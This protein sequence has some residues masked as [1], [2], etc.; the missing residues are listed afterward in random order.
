MRK[1]TMRRSVLA[2]LAL[3][4]SADVLS[5]Q[6][7]RPTSP[8]TRRDDAREVLHGVELVDPYRWLEDDRSPETR[9]WIEAGRS[10]FSM[11]PRPA[12]P[13]GGRSARSWTTS[14]CSSRSWPENWE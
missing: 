6:S 13:A 10:S 7:A 3:G 12:M 5:S 1:V 11:T 9:E 14:R 2:A 4:L 8:S